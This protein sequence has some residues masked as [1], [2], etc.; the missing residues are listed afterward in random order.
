MIKKLKTQNSNVKTY[1]RKIFKIGVVLFVFFGSVYLF[2]VRPGL[3]IYAK[4]NELRSYVPRLKSAFKENDI[5]K[6]KK[7]FKEF[8][9]KYNEFESE[10]KSIYWARYI[11]FFGAY[12]ADFKNGVEAGT[13]LIKALDKT[14]EAVE[15]HADLI[16]FKK[17]EASFV[18][19]PVEER[20]K[21]AVFTLQQIK[22]DIDAISENMKKA[23]ENLEKIDPKRYPKSLFGKRVREKVEEY[24]DQLVGI[25][26]FFVDAKDL[27]KNLP[28]I[29]GADR[30]KT[31]FVIF[32]NDKELRATGGFWTAYSI[33]KIDKGNIRLVKSGDIYDIDNTIKNHPEAPFEILNYHK[34]VYKLYLRDINLSPDFYISVK[35]FEEL[36]SKSQ[37]SVDYDGIIA[38]DTKVLVDLL[39]I[40]GDTKVNGIVFSAKID[41]RCDCP[42]AIYKLFDI[43]DRPTPYL[44]ENRKGILGDL[45]LALFYKAIGFSPSRYWGRLFNAMIKNLDEKHILLYFE[46]EKLQKSIEK[47]GFAGRIKDYKG[48]YF[49][50]NDV[51]FAG[52]KSNMF[53]RHYITSETEIEEGKVI[54]RLVVEYKNPYPHS[55]CNLERG[56]LCLNAT[57]RNWV[58]IYVPKG[59]KL[60]KFVGSKKK[61]R[62]YEDLGKT[63][64]EGFLTVSP[65]GKAVIKIE[66]EVPKNNVIIDGKY[67]LLI[68]KQPGTLGHDLKVKLNGKEIFEDKLLKDIEIVS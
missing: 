55:D 13:F 32:Q 44:R 50:I 7:E 2:L 20:I 43:I 30:E 31:Y 19:K 36:Y 39:E 29:L 18:E 3:K 9:Q 23:E 49:H 60:I 68:Q 57:L 54:R 38:I 28:E 10:A 24:K 34:G 26:K 41:K 46:D 1:K 6:L 21:T 64:F 59:S 22:P 58:R 65:K 63:V 25:T 17:G 42:Q 67:K 16:G 62:V 37:A 66:Y 40:F 56:G 53:V 12:V 61:V 11:P 5:E 14:I 47:L 27:I 45:T 51:N 35:K 4:A 33:F 8:K 15:P 48:D 52:A